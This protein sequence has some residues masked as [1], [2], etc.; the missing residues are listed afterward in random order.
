MAGILLFLF[1]GITFLLGKIGAVPSEAETVI[2]QLA[3][4]TFNSRGL[5]YL[6]AI[7]GT[8]IILVLATNTANSRFGVA[9]DYFKIEPS[10]APPQ[11]PAP[12]LRGLTVYLPLVRR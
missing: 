12:D 3:R 9:F 2:S 7:A 6:S 5:L 10:T 4:T 8:T 1:L 11:G